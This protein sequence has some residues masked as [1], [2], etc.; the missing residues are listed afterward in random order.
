[1]LCVLAVGL[2]CQGCFPLRVPE[3]PGA[4]GVVVDA[5]TRAPL[6]GAEVLVSRA[7]FHSPPMVR[8]VTYGPDNPQPI[9]APTMEEALAYARPPLVVTGADGR[10]CIP[11]RDRWIIY[12]VPMDIWPLGT[13]VV[14]REGYAGRVIMLG[15]AHRSGF[16]EMGEIALEPK[17]E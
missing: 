3:S 11:E 6:A 16:I 5:R 9:I 10:F 1:M 17:K 12:I 7:L 8:G 2:L 4:S 15:D 13:L 14:Q